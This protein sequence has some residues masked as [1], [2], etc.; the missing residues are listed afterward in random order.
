MKHELV[1]ARN[2]TG[3][4]LKNQNTMLC[5]YYRGYAMVTNL[6]SKA[7]CY[8]AVV[9]VV[10]PGEDMTTPVNQWLG[11][12][13]AQ[14]PFCTGG[15]CNGQMLVAHIAIDKKRDVTAQ[16]LLSFYHDVTGWLA[17]NGM[18]SVCEGCGSGDT[19]LYN[20]AGR[21]HVVCPN[22]LE[23]MSQ[24]ARA[25]QKAVP[26]NLP[27]GIAGA[28]LFS[29]AGVA[30]WV[31]VNRLGYV[32]AI[33]GLVLMVCAFKG[34]EKFSGKLDT[35]GIL[36]CVAVAILMGLVSQYVCIGLDIYEVFSDYGVGLLEC[37]RAVPGFLFDPELELL[38]A[39]LPDL[40]FGYLFMAVGSFSFVRNALAAQRHGGFLVEKLAERPEGYG[41]VG[42]G[43]DG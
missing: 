36:V 39:Y 5:G 31:L 32:A 9:W 24:A 30:L 1:Q 28:I 43:G 34:Y 6:N 7:R 23:Q 29:L 18:V 4:Q 11:E 15:S 13:P 19:S 10:R 20:M 41:G 37:M 26:G 42:V 12:Y 3:M 21:L 22:C 40:L 27:T 35:A 8:D 16:S 38:S 2:A 33:C 14:H 25:E 17:A